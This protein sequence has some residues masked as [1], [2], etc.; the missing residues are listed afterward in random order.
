MGKLCEMPPKILRLPELLDLLK[1]LRKGR[2]RSLARHPI[3]LRLGIFNFIYLNRE[4]TPPQLACVK[5][6]ISSIKCL[7]HSRCL[8]YLVLL[9]L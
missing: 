8:C 4:T 6:R 1:S 9:L 7:A 5:I 2:S 3:L